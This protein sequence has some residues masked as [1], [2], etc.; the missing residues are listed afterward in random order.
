MSHHLLLQQSGRRMLSIQ[1][2]IR[3]GSI[4]KGRLSF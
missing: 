1:E 2:E 3:T 4:D